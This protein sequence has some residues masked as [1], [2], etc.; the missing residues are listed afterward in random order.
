[1]TGT[2]LLFSSSEAALVELTVAAAHLYP[3][4]PVSRS[5]LSAA[6]V[7]APPGPPAVPPDGN[8]ALPLGE[9]SVPPGNSP[10]LG[11]P[12]PPERPGNSPEP[13]SPEPPVRP[14]TVPP[15]GS[16]PPPGNEPPAGAAN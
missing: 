1:M 4:A 11:R 15:L 13:G 8:P 5:L 6:L 9:R 7:V 2:P 14:G 12:L 10:E 16:L 3:D